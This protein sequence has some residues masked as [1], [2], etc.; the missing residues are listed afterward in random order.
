MAI[1]ASLVKELREKTNAGMMDCKRALTET[2]GDL[3]AAIKL[4]REKGIAKAAKKADREAKE[5]VVTSVIADDRRSGI[6]VEV[7]CETDFVA[8]NESFQNFVNEIACLL[9][10]SSATS[11]EQALEVATDEGTV[12]DKVKAKVLE[13]GEN[14][15]LS[16]FARL[17]LAENQAGIIA[18]YI[19][20]GGKVGVLTQ[21]SCANA[22]TAENASFTQLANDLNLHIAF[23]NPQGMT[24]NDIDG[25]VIEGEREVYAAQ[26]RNE[27]KPDNIIDKIVEGKI[28]KFYNQ[29]VL[30]EQAFVKD[31][32]HSVE[33]YIKEQGKQI[34]DQLE[35]QQF[36]R[37]AIGG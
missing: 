19:H 34:G 13:V 24:R 2:N 23:S 5:G 20:L 12:G 7:N 16:N 4:L 32:D 21:L 22:A 35:L 31:S 17:S 14:L 11:L 18:S 15:I 8:K 33:N 1:S 27:G 25:S 28:N 10:N 9:A 37:F 29:I 36:V 26:L 30:L 6:L 3:D